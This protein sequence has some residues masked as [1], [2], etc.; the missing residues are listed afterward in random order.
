MLRPVRLS[1]VL[2]AIVALAPPAVYADDAKSDAPAPYDTFVKGATLTPGLLTVVRK[3]GKVYLSIAKSQLG[4][5]FIETSVPETGL[6]GFGPAPG[7]PY[8]APARIMRFERQ[9]DNLILRW[10]NTFARVDAN[11]PRALS[12]VASLPGSVVAVA[13]IVAESP[14][15]VV[16]AANP[17]L[18]DVADLKAQFDAVATKPDHAYRLDPARSFFTETKSFP[19]NTLLRVSQ[20]WATDS[21]DT[22]DNVPDARSIE[23]KMSYNIIAAPDNHYMPRIS[24]PRVGYF[25]QPLIDFRNDANPTRSVYYAIRWPFMPAALDRP[26]G[27]RNPLVFTLSNDIPAEYR[28][29]VKQALLTW[30]DAFNR[31]GIQNAIQVQQEPDDPSF[32]V[33]DIRHN[34]VSWFD[35]ST[36]QYGAE[37]LIV[38]DPR[39]GEEINVGINV[40]SVVGLAGAQVYRY[41]VAPARHLPDNAGLEQ[42]FAINLIRAIVLHESGHDFGLQH[43]FIGSMAYTAHQL[44]DTGFTSRFGV[45]SSVMEY[46]PINFWPAGTRQGDYVQLGLGPYDYHAIAFGYE[47]IPGAASPEA[48]VPELNRLAGSWADPLLRFASDEDVSFA[49]GH[50]VDPRVQ[51]DDL[52]SHPLEWE[53]TQLTMLH[54]IMNAVDQH[55]PRMGQSYVEARYAFN[56]PLSMYNRTVVMP[57]HIIGGEYMSRSNAGDPHGRPPLT[58]VA[59]SDEYAAWKALETFLF[60]DAAWRYS[61]AVLERLTYRE[62]ATLNVN[63][64]WVYNPPPRHDIAIV[65]VA[66]QT[67]DRVMNELFAPLT[68]Q[69]ID[70]LSTKYPTATTMSLT[71]LFDWTRA[72]LFGDISSGKIGGAG[73]V[74]R[75]AQMRFARRL[76]QLWIA[77][78]AGTPTDAQALAR[79]QLEYL[80]HDVAVALRGKQTEI[81]RAHLEALGALAHQAL[82]ARATMADPSDGTP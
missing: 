37:A 56:V 27:A 29:T 40:D 23:V 57:A 54:G 45:A 31:I 3:G 43:N 69:R 5:D 2:A 46:A 18:G 12:A 80:T 19:Q 14:T 77:P 51:Q 4:T 9:D 60:S 74:R 48:E 75:N 63:A 66:G 50:A 62:V 81:T 76:A 36:P 22:I 52:T 1:F 24:D 55:F 71:D 73:V 64:T 67:Q 65:E 42:Q 8:V 10:P 34:M 30:N 53:R 32:D 15:A 39:T 68:L 61:P 49:S 11:T 21:P 82:E 25:E 47:N 58:P 35:A 26:S 16:I 6:G 72:G 78:A 13:P 70:D 17:F 44:Q 20:T 33:D 38:D 7:E 79:L 28:D 41:V 59:R